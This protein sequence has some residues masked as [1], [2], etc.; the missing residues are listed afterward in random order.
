MPP[1]MVLNLVIV[2]RRRVL[3]YREIKPMTNASS[4]DKPNLPCTNPETRDMI[5]RIL[6]GLPPAPPTPPAR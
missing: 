5:E 6:K 4:S 3:N 1:P 2:L